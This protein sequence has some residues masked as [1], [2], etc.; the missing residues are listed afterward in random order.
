MTVTV[1][2]ILREGTVVLPEVPPEIRERPV[3]VALLQDA[4]AEPGVLRD[5]E[6]SWGYPSTEAGSGQAAGS[7]LQC[8]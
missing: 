1:K 2:A 7:P 5:G 8:T 4:A 3:T 6:C